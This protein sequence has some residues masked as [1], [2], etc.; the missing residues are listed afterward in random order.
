MLFK[1]QLHLKL[2]IP[3]LAAGLVTAC[4]GEKAVSGETDADKATSE[5]STGQAL[6][7]GDPQSP[8]NDLLGETA[9]GQRQ[10][11]DQ[12]QTAEDL[13]Q[14]TWQC[15]RQNDLTEILK[16][17]NGTVYYSYY[18]DRPGETWSRSEGT[19][20]VTDTQVITTIND[21]NSYFDYELKNNGLTLRHYIDSGADG[22][23]TYTLFQTEKDAS[24]EKSLNDTETVSNTGATKDFTDY[25]FETKTDAAGNFA[26]YELKER[27]SKHQNSYGNSAANDRYGNSAANNSY[28][29]SA[30]TGERNALDK[31]YSY[32]TYTA[33]SY[34]GLIDQL[35][36]EGFTPSEARYGADHCGTDWNEQA[37][38][39]AQQYLEY[40]SFSRSG[41]I[42]QLEFEGF[43]RSEAEYGVS[44]VY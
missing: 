12:I 22:G 31:A 7:G 32:L 35:E 30:T 36:F 27:S 18:L 9:G 33:F 13:L 24:L 42:D 34:T 17:K 15:D 21:H 1:H 11:E 23:T 5:Y 39:K 41:L 43:T 40:S 16:F 3:I 44:Q 8:K 28:G 20:R 26:G 25:T 2:F 14:G 29:S 38:K 4:S 10:E 37:A 6:S 19:Y